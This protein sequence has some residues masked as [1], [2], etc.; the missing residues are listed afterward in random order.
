MTFIMILCLD[1]RHNSPVACWTEDQSITLSIC[2]S[3][4]LPFCLYLSPPLLLGSHLYAGSLCVDLNYALCLYGI[5][6]ITCFFVLFI[7]SGVKVDIERIK[8]SVSVSVTDQALL[9]QGCPR[10]QGSGIAITAP[11]KTTL[12]ILSLRALSRLKHI[13]STCTSS[14]HSCITQPTMNKL[15]AL[16]LPSLS[17]L[18]THWKH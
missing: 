6:N 1:A 10:K 11:S 17:R 13:K 8:N 9:A 18:R 2:M 14:T 7:S 16:A 12:K 15:E 5:F 4:G 3:I